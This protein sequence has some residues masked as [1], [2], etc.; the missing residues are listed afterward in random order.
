MSIITRR[1]AIAGAATLPLL[2]AAALAAGGRLGKFRQLSLF[3]QPADP[4]VA[5]HRDWLA[6]YDANDVFLAAG[7]DDE[8]PE[9]L[10]MYNRVWAARLALS[11]VVATT[12]AGLALQIRFAFV[13]FGDLGYGGDIESLDDFTF[14]NVAENQEGRLLRFMLAAAENM[15]GEGV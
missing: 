12:P 4:A 11:D 7:K 1:T 2:P 13:M 8:T 14:D 5:A 10:A 3:A 9:G 6:A 15:A